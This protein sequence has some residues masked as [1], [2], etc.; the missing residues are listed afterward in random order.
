MEGIWRWS[1]ITAVAPVAW[2]T[3]YYV[4]GEFLPPDRPLYGAAIRAL[5]AGLLLL[6]LSRTL[7]SGSW[8]WKS[9]VLGVLNMGG[10]FALV[11]VAAQRLPTSV[12]STV[13]ALAP[14]VMAV[15][16]WP[17]V[18]ERPRL[19]QLAAAVAGAAGVCLMLLTASGST[20]P[21]GILASAGA[22]AMSSCGYLLAKRWS[23]GVGTLASTSWQL[24]AGGLVLLVAAGIVEGS[25]PALDAPAVAGFA[26]VALVGTALAF[27]AW[28]GG[29]RRLPA[30]TVGLV[31]LLN[32]VTGVL[33]GVVAAH[34]GLTGRQL[35]GL[36]LTLASVGF[37]RPPAAAEL[38]PADP[39]SPR[40]GP[41]PRRAAPG[42]RE[43]WPASGA[44]RRR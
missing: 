22:M 14:L 39:P 25:P 41:R 23:E 34:E 30:A 15:L 31:G 12:A 5:P 19:R 7:P 33:L 27:V 2:G 20:D 24:V 4:T 9:L 44:R 11:Y 29:L 8:W 26:Y 35:F 28:F 40:Y 36:A 38:R 37:A 16:A 32:P 18:G 43:P 10:F 3:T 21:A 42:C 6:A 1:L 13:M 17:L